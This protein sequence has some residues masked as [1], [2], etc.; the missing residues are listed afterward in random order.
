MV[1]DKYSKNSIDYEN[2]QLQGCQ[3]S[4]NNI[5]VMGK[6]KNAFATKMVPSSELHFNNAAKEP[7]SAD[8]QVNKACCLYPWM[9]IFQEKGWAIPKQVSF[10]YFCTFFTP[11]FFQA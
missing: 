7:T 4:L 2:H 10:W 5:S 1:V 8:I 3:L 11:F 6:V 9:N